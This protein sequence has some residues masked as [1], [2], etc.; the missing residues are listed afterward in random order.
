MPKIYFNWT[1]NNF[2]ITVFSEEPHRKHGDIAWQIRD[3]ILYK[4]RLGCHARKLV[5]EDLL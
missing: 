1:R 2:D 3:G 4:G 5:F